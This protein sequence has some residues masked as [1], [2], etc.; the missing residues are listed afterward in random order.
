MCLIKAVSCFVLLENP[1]SSAIVGSASN[2]YHHYQKQQQQIYHVLASSSSS[3]D[4]G[5]VDLTPQEERAYQFMKEIHD[6]GYPFRV[7]VVGGR[8]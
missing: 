4:D 2:R 8:G 7:V 3:D 1:T 5:G 6:S